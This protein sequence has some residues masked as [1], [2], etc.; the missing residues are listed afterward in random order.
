MPEMERRILTAMLETREDEGKAR[1]IVGHAAVFDQ[2]SEDLGGWY[3]R[4]KPGAFASSI[5]RDDIRGLWNH[6]TNWVLGRNKSGTL[7]LS[8][9][10]QGLAIEIDTPL[11]Q[12]AQDLMI[13]IRR[14]DIDQMS[15]GFWTLRDE[16]KVEGDIVIRDVHEVKLFDVSPV[17]AAAY[18]QTDVGVRLD[19]LS[20]I[21]V[22]MKAGKASAAELKRLN[23]M[24][25]LLNQRGNQVET[26][27]GGHDQAGL[28]MRRRLLDLL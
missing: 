8:E 4:M 11:T 17:T 22:R 6:D 25:N 24:L 16:W 19:D 1:R 20:E 26:A 28:A 5:G 14:G 21:S 3:E 7:R 12:W 9:D 15:I 18:P 2:L 13:S 23:E 10:A 27:D